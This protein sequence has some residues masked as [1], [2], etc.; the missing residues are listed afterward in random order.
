MALF[1]RKST[2]KEEK[3][4]KE[5]KVKEEKKREPKKTEKKAIAASSKWDDSLRLLKAPHITEKATKISSINFYVFKVNSKANK[6]QIKKAIETLYNVDVQKVNIM[7]IKRKKRGA[8]RLE[9]YK[10]GYK[11]A[12]VKIGKGQK[13]EVK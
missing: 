6:Q 8:G 10:S 9:G 7:N 4:K 2:Q 13:I 11:K 3:P 1:G 12:L 5:E